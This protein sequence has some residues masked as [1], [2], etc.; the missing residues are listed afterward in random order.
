MSTP[1]DKAD[2]SVQAWQQFLSML[3]PST[4]RAVQEFKPRTPLAPEQPVIIPDEETDSYRA[5]RSTLS[6]FASGQLD[7]LTTAPAQEEAV[8]LNEKLARYCLIECP[9]GDWSMIRMFKSPEG[10]A[11]RIGQLEG[12]DTV[13]WAV[14]GIPLRITKG[15]QRYLLLP[16]GQTALTVPVIEGGP[17]KQVDADLLDSLELQDDGY[18]GPPELAHAHAIT[19]QKKSSPPALAKGKKKAKDDDD[20]E[21]DDDVPT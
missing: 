8:E 19:R 13:V 5:F 2:K 16:D 10:L 20:N 21:E 15:P 14:F 6:A 4:K 17:V 7:E 3:T 9:D 18:I 12:E 11:R 1:N